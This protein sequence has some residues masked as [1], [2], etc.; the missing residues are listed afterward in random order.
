MGKG[1]KNVTDLSLPVSLSDAG[2]DLVPL[3]LI[4]GAQAVQTKDILNHQGPN[5]LLK[6][7]V[8]TWVE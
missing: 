2:G 4:G 7:F 8:C 1:R 6:G 5:P 3:V